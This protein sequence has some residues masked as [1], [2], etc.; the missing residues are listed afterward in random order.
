MAVAFQKTIPLLR[1]FDVEKAKEFYVYYLGFSV[2]WEHHFEDNT[3][4]YIQVSRDGQESTTSTGR[5]RTRATSTC[6]L[7]V[8]C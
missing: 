3:P 8:G 1:I 5:S 4:A 6:V 2:D 7:A